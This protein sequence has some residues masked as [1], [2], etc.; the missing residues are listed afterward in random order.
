MLEKHN[1]FNYKW[2]VQF[3]IKFNI[4]FLFEQIEYH[5]F[6]KRLINDFLNEWIK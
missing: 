5:I 2:H 4:L 1:K 3:A 6:K